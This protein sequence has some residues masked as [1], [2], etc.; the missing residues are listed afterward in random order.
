M[1]R[2]DVAS[3]SRVTQLFT[4]ISRNATATV[5][6]TEVVGFDGQAFIVDVG[7]YTS[8]TGFDITFQHRDGTGSYV[9]IPHEQL[10]SPKALTDSKI[11]IREADEDK[12]F[13]VT[14]T[15]SHKELGAV[16]TRVG[17]GIMVLGVSVLKGDKT[18]FPA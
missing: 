15:G 7:A 9:D 13:Y 4:K 5:Q 8:G 2:S 17:D 11:S 6:G 10:D 3:K 12:Q 16:L 1:G 18:Q 14:Y